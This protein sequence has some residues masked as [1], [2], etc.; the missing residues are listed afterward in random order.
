MQC[1]DCEEYALRAEAFAARILTAEATLAAVRQLADDWERRG[2][3][4]ELTDDDAKD[5]VIIQTTI[6]MHMCAEL[7]RRVLTPT[8]EAS[9]ER[10]NHGN[11]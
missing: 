7:L 2:Q 11:E 5:R 8:P 1:P 3:L 9:K 10:S 6:T 4:S